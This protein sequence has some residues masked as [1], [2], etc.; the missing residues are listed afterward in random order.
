MFPP[1]YVSFHSLISEIQEKQKVKE[2]PKYEES[3]KGDED[4]S[5][6]EGSLVSPENDEADPNIGVGR[7]H[8]SLNATSRP[9]SI[10]FKSYL[11]SQ[12]VG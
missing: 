1:Q 8:V 3:L 5:N 11:T 6:V 2:K 12:G 10:S 4:I 7:E 9:R